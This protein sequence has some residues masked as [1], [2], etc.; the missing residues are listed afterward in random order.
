MKSLVLN[1]DYRPLRLVPLSTVSWKEA[2]TMI[3]QNKAIA[4]AHHDKYVHSPSITMKVPSVV[5]L[6]SYKKLRHKAK[7]SKFHVKLRDNFTCQYCGNTFS[8]K[9]LTVDHVKPKCKGG[10]TSFNNLVAACKACNQTKKHETKMKP[11][12]KP[13]TPTYWEL[14]KAAVDNNIIPKHEEDWNEYINNYF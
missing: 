5:V 6:T 12:T 10:K 1:A 7:F 9:S 3:Y 11:L 8:K 4:I 14:A 2:I 13:R